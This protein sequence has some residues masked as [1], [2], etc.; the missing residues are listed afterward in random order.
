MFDIQS[1][2]Y[3][4]CGW[5]NESDGYNDATSFEDLPL[6]RATKI[7][8]VNYKYIVKTKITHVNQHKIINQHFNN[9]LNTVQRSKSHMI[10]TE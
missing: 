3:S 4:L 6:H 8:S 1:F 2:C 10:S 9:K 7:N 5:T